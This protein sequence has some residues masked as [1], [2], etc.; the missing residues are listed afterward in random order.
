MGSCVLRPYLYSS[1]TSMPDDMRSCT[2]FSM[3]RYLYRVENQL[4]HPR[5]APAAS[6]L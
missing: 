1:S 2:Q 4:R 6:L 3:R 5:Q